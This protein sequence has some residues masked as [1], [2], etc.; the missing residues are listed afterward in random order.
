MLIL[1][2]L[3][4]AVVLGIAMHYATPDPHGRGVVLVP[5]ISTAVAAVVWGTMTWMG[6]ADTNFW[7]WLASVVVPIIVTYPIS[8]WIA[9]SRMSRDAA[10]RARLGVV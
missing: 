10:E 2:P 3:V 8:L 6:F 7:I 9:A 1:L 4:V 5:A